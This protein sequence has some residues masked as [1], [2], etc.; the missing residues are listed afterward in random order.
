MSGAY[1]PHLEIIV[2]VYAVIENTESPVY[3]VTENT[4][5][6]VYAVTENTESPVY[7]VTE[8]TENPVAKLQHIYDICKKKRLF[9]NFS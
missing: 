1:R 9:V 2:P 4:D 5:S 8:N 3:A 7:A 6:P